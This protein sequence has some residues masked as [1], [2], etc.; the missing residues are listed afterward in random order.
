MK[1]MKKLC[2]SMFFTTIMLL[3]IMNNSN[4]ATQYP[5][6]NNKWFYIKNAYT[7]QYLDVYNGYGQNDTNV[8]QCKYNG[9]Y[10]QKWGIVH[11][12][13]GEYMIWSG[14]AA[15]IEGNTTYV[16]FALDLYNGWADN[17]TNI[18]IYTWNT[19]NFAQ[20]FSFQ[21][22]SKDTY[23]IRTKASGFNSVVTLASNSCD[24]G[25][26]VCEWEYS[27]IA[28]NEWILEPVENTPSFGI[29]YATSNYNKK[30]EAYPQFGAYGNEETNFVSQCLLAGGQVHQDN[31]WYMRRKNSNYSYINSE[32]NLKNSW[33]ASSSWYQLDGFKNL[34]Y[35]SARR[36]VFWK[37]SMI[38]ND[39]T[40]P[41]EANF[42]AGDVMQIATLNNGMASYP[43]KSYYV[44][45]HATKSLFLTTPNVIN[46]SLDYLSQQYSDYAI[47]F[48]DFTK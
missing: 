3:L 45:A 39:V 8:Q 32:S 46:T 36:A 43:V 35:N 27:N 9:S 19:G 44:S 25:V 29:S 6:L 14:C 47:V 31:N 22:T 5:E 40:L 48:Y 15:E 4:A 33:D 37:G 1:T 7:G 21:K 11:M 30:V 16:E 28:R 18:Q 41:Y 42:R 38:A 20:R 26:N 23:I 10:A 2:I 34:Y 13:N 12:E 17:W 24:D